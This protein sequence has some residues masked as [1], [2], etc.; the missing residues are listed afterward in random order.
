MTLS[1]PWLRQLKHSRT[2]AVLYDNYVKVNPTTAYIGV[3]TLSGRG[4]PSALVW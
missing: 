3:D 1:D 2:P 4:A